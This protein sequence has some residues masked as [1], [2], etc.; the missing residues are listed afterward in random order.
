MLSVADTL[1]LEFA[2][3]D[4]HTGQAFIRSKN[5][6]DLAYNEVK[7]AFRSLKNDGFLIVGKPVKTLGAKATRLTARGLKR[8][9]YLAQL[10]SK[11]SYIQPGKRLISPILVS[12]LVL[13]ACTTPRL[14]NNNDIHNRGSLR[15]CKLGPIRT[16]LG[17]SPDERVED[18]LEQRACGPFI[19]TGAFA[20]KKLVVP[21]P[22]EVSFKTISTTSRP[23]PRQ[24]ITTVSVNDATNDQPRLAP[25]SLKSFSGAAAKGKPTAPSYSPLAAAVFFETNSAMLGTASTKKIE[26]TVTGKAKH[27][28]VI[29]STDP[30]GTHARNLKL[31]KAR[32]LA[33]A[34]VLISMGVSKTQIRIK[35]KPRSVAYDP[36]ALHSA[37]AA[38]PMDL[39]SIARRVEIHVTPQ[40]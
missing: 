5:I 31:A 18:L 20:P 11:Q 15:D 22:V 26:Q 2:N 24:I 19:G 39:Y 25:V 29:A 6:E 16:P 12:T 8:K 7:R 23:D 1:L 27:Y 32:G 36:Q 17:S 33:A 34:K 28:L 40:T 10:S 4:W 37:I 21:E 3:N 38:H 14:H 9:Q 30:T 35:L 13:G